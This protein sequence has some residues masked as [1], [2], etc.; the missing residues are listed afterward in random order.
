MS[1]NFAGPTPPVVPLQ[2]KR[3]GGTLQLDNQNIVQA[4]FGG[5][6]LLRTLK[7]Y[8]HVR[9]TKIVEKLKTKVYH[10]IFKDK[11]VDLRF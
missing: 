1:K 11:M 7:I 6:N 9:T 5:S 10:L 3:W 4:N 8:K 2:A